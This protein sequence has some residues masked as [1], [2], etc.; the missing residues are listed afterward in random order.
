MA[1]LKIP[2]SKTADSEPNEYEIPLLQ[3]TGLGAS[4]Q[5]ADNGEAVKIVVQLNAAP[6][7]DPFSRITVHSK[8]SVNLDNLSEFSSQGTIGSR[9]ARAADQ[10]ANPAELHS[11]VMNYLSQVPPQI[12]MRVCGSHRSPADANST[13]ID[14]N[15]ILDLRGFFGLQNDQDWRIC[16]I[17]PHD[18]RTHRGTVM[19]EVETTP[20]DSNPEA[21]VGAGRSL[22]EWCEHYCAE[23]SFRKSFRVT[24][25]VSGIDLDAIQTGVTSLLRPQYLG[26]LDIGFT[27][28][29][30][31]VD[32]YPASSLDQIRVEHR[33]G[34]LILN[35]LLWPVL[36]LWGL[37]A[38][39]FAVSL[40][41]LVMMFLF[42]QD[43]SGV[44]RWA[45]TYFRNLGI[46]IG[47]SA[48]V[49]LIY[50]VLYIL[51]AGP[52]MTKKWNIYTVDWAVSRWDESSGQPV[53]KYAGLSEA[54]WIQSHAQFLR[55]L[56]EGNFEGDATG[57][58]DSRNVS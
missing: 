47:A 30:E 56:V 5:H 2:R 42:D 10:L 19:Q 55:R 57:F 58:M 39:V 31:S 43:R 36:A 53:K 16:S 51:I 12:Y 41:P 38:F 18:V 33:R 50:L 9:S 45:Y 52:F 17:T 13:I 1:K 25:E 7:Q 26:K 4:E 6:L 8:R 40:V 48:A 49:I 20:N 14:F 28:V 37:C 32:I 22:F 11:Y 35:T 24:R 34:E 29:D 27:I 44:A 21:G 15:F 3:N 46:F 54:E 23:V